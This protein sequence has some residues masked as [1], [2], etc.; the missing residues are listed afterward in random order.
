MRHECTFCVH[1]A[2]IYDMQ[3]SYFLISIITLIML[4]AL[5]GVFMSLYKRIQSV[6]Q[7]HIVSSTVEGIDTS[8]WLTYENKEYEFRFRYPK[9]WKVKDIDENTIGLVSPGL[10]EELKTN[11]TIFNSDLY[12]SIDRSVKGGEGLEDSLEQMVET[13]EI[14]NLQFIGNDRAN[15]IEYNSF[16]SD[17]QLVHYFLT[18]KEIAVVASNLIS[19]ANFGIKE[20]II[21]SITNIPTS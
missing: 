15:F 13:G 1:S 19:S 9:T 10:E 18:N 6:K 11:P 8:D 14:T 16:L 17:D 5:G 3:R 2:I 21:S 4:I 7:A 20:A 12:L